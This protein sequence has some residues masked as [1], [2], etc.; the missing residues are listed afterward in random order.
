MSLTSWADDIRGAARWIWHPEETAGRQDFVLF[1][2]VLTPPAGA[3][4]AELYVSGDC[5]YT[6]YADAGNGVQKLGRGP[7]RSNPEHTS[8]DPYAIGGL[9]GQP[10]K[11]WA[12]VRWGLALNENAYSE[13]HAGVPGLLVAA[14]YRDGADKILGKGGS[15]E[16]WLACRSEAIKKYNDPSA[17]WLF[18][19]GG[20]EEHRASGWPT[21]WL[22]AA[23][24]A[25]NAAWKKV[26]VRNV[27]YFKGDAPYAS[28]PHFLIPREIS[29]PEEIP[30]AF[31]AAAPADHPGEIK[32]IGQVLP[33]KVAANQSVSI[34]LDAGEETVAYPQLTLRGG[35][36]RAAMM[37]AE[38]LRDAQKNKCYKLAPGATIA[39]ASDHFVLDSGDPQA[40]RTFETSHWRA[41]RF[42]KLDVTAGPY[43]AEVDV[44]FARTSYPFTNEMAL[45]TEG[46]HAETIRKM[47]DVSWRTLKCCSWETHMDCPYYEQLQYI[48]DTRLQVLCTYVATQDISLAAQALRAY[49]RS[50]THEGL[51]YSRYPSAEVQLI[52]TFSLLYIL[53][54]DDYLTHAGDEGLV[55]EL[56]PGIGGI[57]NWF[58][59][60]IDQKT[61]LIGEVPYWPFVDWVR[62]WPFGMSPGPVSA[63]INLHYLMALDAAARIYE[64]QRAGAGQFYTARAQVWRQKIKD[65]FFDR[66]TG[67]ISDTP[68]GMDRRGRSFSQHAQAMAILTDVLTGD[69]ARD[70]LKKCL[71]PERVAKPGMSDDRPELE[72]AAFSEMEANL[73]PDER[74]VPASIYFSFYVGEAVAK[75]RMGELFWPMMVH[76]RKALELGSTTWP[77]SPEP[78]RSECHAWGSWPMY[79]FSRYVLGVNP[80]EPDTGR[81]VIRPL[82]CPPLDNVSG[83]VQTQRGPVHVKVTWV[84]GKAEVE[85]DGPNVFVSKI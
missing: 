58:T 33:L 82:Y 30:G 29:Y 14:V 77:E 20:M 5:R 34:I 42:I 2:G 8:I 78:A 37:Y 4:V 55:A 35:E 62:Q 56:R 70:A 85:A 47:M 7:A 84:D 11:V 63:M 79:F 21:E 72:R 40:V 73:P 23:G 51:T 45:R 6:I 38:V 65:V 39:G 69:E 61:G 26:A 71:E 53:M 76:H 12:W 22:S 17:W 27:P 15:G 52:P 81:I 74:I 57:L 59:H 25:E 36:T 9:K 13:M 24:A 41:F 1:Y 49:D 68:V 43:G 83:T 66:F 10:I 48:G 44:A 31:V 67:L 50:R 75:L 64:A 54:I 3:E 32:P 28:D 80:P 46:P 18:W 19:I 60:Y 16:G